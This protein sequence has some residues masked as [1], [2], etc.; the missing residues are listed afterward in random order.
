MLF[1]R[2]LGSSEDGADLAVAFALGHP[3]QHFSLAGGE[4]ERGHQGSSGGKIGGEW[5][6]IVVLNAAAVQACFHYRHE[7]AVL[8]RLGQVVICAE[9]HASALVELFTTGS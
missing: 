6:R 3:Q 2:A 9:V 1:H 4:T 7:F 8:D 5:L